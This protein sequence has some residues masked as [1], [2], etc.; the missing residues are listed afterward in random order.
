MRREWHQS[1]RLRANSYAEHA[2]RGLI[3]LFPAGPP[4]WHLMVL[5]FLNFGLRP[6]ELGCFSGYLFAAKWGE[7]P[8][9]QL[10][11][12]GLLKRDNLRTLDFT[13]SHARVPRSGASGNLWPRA[14]PGLGLQNSCHASGCVLWRDTILVSPIVANTLFSRAR[15]GSS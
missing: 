6:S 14:E 11:I 2:D 10:H 7:I 8:N 1:P 15:S 4:V 13:A 12:V 3:N 9:S 5:V